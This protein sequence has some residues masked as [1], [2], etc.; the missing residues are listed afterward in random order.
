MSATNPLTYGFRAIRRDPAL[1][2][3]EILWRWSFGAIMVFLLLGFLATHPESLVVIDSV[4]WGSHDPV[5]IAQSLI[6][7]VM[8]L[9]S[10]WPTVA[11]FILT[12]TAFWILLGALG[13][14]LTLN[15]L[16][17]GGVSLRAMLALQFL[18]ALCFWGAV[19]VLIGSITFESRIAENGAQQDLFLYFALAGGSIIVIGALWAVVNWVLSLAAICCAR[20]AGGAIRSIHQ[21]LNLSRSHSGDLFGVG[22][23]FAIPRA[24]ALNVAFV[25]WFLPSG[26][27][28]TAP[29]SYFAW[30]TAVTLAYFAV[31]D[32]LYL[33]RMA[34]Y[35]VVD[36]PDLGNQRSGSSALA[37]SDRTDS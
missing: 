19:S 2:L 23:V 22:L 14:M 8:S 6:R 18:R 1:L 32:W 11:A 3:I 28:A 20:N 36:V 26:M 7:A 33:A 4:P 31:S 5:L 35:L 29:K 9:A 27:M 17:K 16:E 10:R 34:G 25:L 13:R 21:A 12:A 24:V 37:G 15:R 30:T